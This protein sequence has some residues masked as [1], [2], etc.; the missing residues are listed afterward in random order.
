MITSMNAYYNKEVR[1]YTNENGQESWFG[2]VTTR[3]GHVL[4]KMVDFS[5]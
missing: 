3:A 4:S 5:L 1:F 2:L